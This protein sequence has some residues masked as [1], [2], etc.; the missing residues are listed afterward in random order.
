MRTKNYLYNLFIEHDKEFLGRKIDN[1]TAF[2]AWNEQV[3][4]AKKIALVAG[5]FS[6]TTILACVYLLFKVL[7]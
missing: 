6:I 7:A 1:E 2:K 4:V 5:I 3:D